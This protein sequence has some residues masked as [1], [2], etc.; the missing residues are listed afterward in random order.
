MVL[1]H[2]LSPKLQR[3]L[4]SFGKEN[5]AEQED[6]RDSCKLFMLIYGMH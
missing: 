5:M 6:V 1:T 2:I 3:L 4:C